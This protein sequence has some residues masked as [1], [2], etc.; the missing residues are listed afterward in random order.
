MQATIEANRP[1]GTVPKGRAEAPAAS[2]SC[3]PFASFAGPRQVEAAIERSRPMGTALIFDLGSQR[4]ARMEFQSRSLVRASTKQAP[5]GSAFFLPFVF[6]AAAGPGYIAAAGH[7]PSA[8][9]SRSAGRT[10]VARQI[11]LVG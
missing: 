6:F 3:L 9:H 7:T 4:K 11:A 5:V 8:S 2:A 10:A 1:W